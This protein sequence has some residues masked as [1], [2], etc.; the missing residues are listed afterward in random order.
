MH[1][2]TM[3]SLALDP[4]LTDEELMDVLARGGQE[5][6]GPLYGRY[7]GLIFHVAAQRLDRAAAEEIVQ[8]VFLSI[9]RAAAT[10]DSTRGSFRPWVLRLTDWRVLSELRRRKR[11]PNEGPSDG[12]DPLGHMPDHDAGPEERASQAERGEAVRTALEMLPPK[13]REALVLAF[14]D[15]LTHQQVAHTLDVPLGT[16]KT[17]IRDGLHRLRPLL[18]PVAAS[19]VLAIVAGVGVIRS[20]LLDRT[21]DR[22][23]HAVAL[24]TSSDTQ[25]TRVEGVAGAPAGMH[26]NYRMRPGAAVAVFS[27]SHATLRTDGATYQAWARIAGR[28]MSLGTFQPDANAE[29]TLVA[30]GP[31]LGTPPDAIA[32]TVEQSGGASTPGD[33]VVLEWPAPEAGS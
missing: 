21:L 10:F 2:G 20:V 29:A 11:R 4:T 26:G 28:W 13:Q 6:L 7:A 14:L 15:D 9:W 30:A 1:N 17:R 27:V 33:R 18:T 16:A 12:A 22:S 25:T 23:E 5:A 31:E 19:L 3:A 24:L 8:D 32:V